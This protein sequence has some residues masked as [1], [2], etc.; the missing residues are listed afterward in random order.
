MSKETN[1]DNMVMT[2]GYLKQVL[3]VIEKEAGSD[4]E[5]WLSSDEEGNEF[6]PMPE[7]VKFSLDV[8]KTLK[9]V[10]LYPDHR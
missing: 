2:V 1:S 3:S 7:N 5:I 9:R 10:T 6:H 8:D 4:F